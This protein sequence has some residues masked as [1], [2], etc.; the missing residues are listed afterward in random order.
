MV[1]LG[2]HPLL[3]A[4]ERQHKQVAR[5][6]EVRHEPPPLNR[7]Q[8]AT[9]AEKQVGMDL[10]VNCGRLAFARSSPHDSDFHWAEAG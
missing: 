4:G 3:L 2:Q 7:S 10:Q 1:G 9:E 6:I 8:A 5:T